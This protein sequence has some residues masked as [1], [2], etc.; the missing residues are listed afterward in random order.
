M[1][2]V[3]EVPQIDCDTALVAAKR[4]RVTK[5]KIFEGAIHLRLPPGLKERIEA[6]R[7]PRRQGEFLRELLLDAV[8][9]RERERDKRWSGP[10]GGGEDDKA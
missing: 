3:P 7:G 2:C 6:L 8:E 9:R 10:A 1:D 5:P 4:G